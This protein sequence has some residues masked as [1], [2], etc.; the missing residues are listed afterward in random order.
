MRASRARGLA[1]AAARGLKP[2]RGGAR[3][4]R[5][6]E[7]L[8]VVA[9]RPQTRAPSP[10][11]APTPRF[12]V[13]IAPS[14]SA[15]PDLAIAL[16]GPGITCLPSTRPRLPRAV[17]PLLTGRA[18]PTGLDI[19]RFQ[20]TAG[21]GGGSSA[22][23]LAQLPG[24]QSIRCLTTSADKRPRMRHAIRGRADD[25]CR[26]ARAT[27]ILLFLKPSIHSQLSTET[28]VGQPDQL[29]VLC[30]G[31]AFGLHRSDAVSRQLYG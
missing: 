9:R 23:D 7:S 28:L 8:P 3:A 24:C 4:A 19:C 2:L 16:P 14:S 21:T 12:A 11:S 26:Q 18:C 25:C 10:A 1:F 20:M 27:R 29:S 17:I 5:F 30:S 6:A 31:P 15:A 13:P 22:A